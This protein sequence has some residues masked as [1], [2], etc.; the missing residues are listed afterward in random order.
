MAATRRPARGREG[1]RSPASIITSR[2]EDL[3]RR[4][5][6]QRPDPK[7]GPDDAAAGVRPRSPR[8]RPS[9]AGW[10][11]SASRSSPRSTAPRSA[12]AWRSRWPATTAS[13]STTPG[14]GLGLPEV[15]LGLLPGGGGVVRIVRMLGIVDALHERAAPGPAAQA[16]EGPG[17][18]HRRR[19]GRH[20]AR[21][22]CPAAKAWIAAE[23]RGA[24][25]PWDRRGYKIPGGTPSTPEAR[26]EPA[27]LPGEPAQAAQGRA[28]Y[29]RRT[30]SWPRRSRARRST[31]TPRCAI[32][33]RYFVDLVDRPGREEHDPG[34]L[35]RPAGDQRRRARGRTGTR[36]YTPRKVAV[37][38]AGMMGAGIAYVCAKA[39][40]EVVLKDVSLE[41]AEKRQ[42]ATPR[43][44]S[45]RASQRGQDHAGEGRRPC[46]RG[47][48][49]PPTP[50]TSRAATS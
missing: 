27:G 36:R 14:V 43:A 19:A 22:C 1:R 10:R 11:R 34:V 49:R 2:Q 47:S 8:S 24:S 29:P 37:L 32:E 50:P 45:R 48:P 18:R 7:A 33:G 17:D 38:G 13:S 21:S 39:G 40:I 12:A 3:L 26:A 46:W 6:P 25:Q 42:G 9:C 41:A 23:P 30:T 5:R 28:N 20:A 15:T 31:S 35:L 4:R 44:W 16:R